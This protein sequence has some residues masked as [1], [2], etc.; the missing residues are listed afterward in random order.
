MTDAS[1]ADV[2]MADG[3]R[4]DAS[5][6]DVQMADELMLARSAHVYSQTVSAQPMQM[7]HTSSP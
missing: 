3:Q 1:M 6:A 2:P 7:V 4:A 5:M